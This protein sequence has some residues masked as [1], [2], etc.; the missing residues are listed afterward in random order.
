MHRPAVVCKFSLEMIN[1]VDL[2]RAQSC[3]Y[4][5]RKG[6]STANWIFLNYSPFSRI[7]LGDLNG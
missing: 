4:R 1:Y 5:I 6:L 2:I 7:E 3:F